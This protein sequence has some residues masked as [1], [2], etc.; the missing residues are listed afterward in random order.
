MAEPV[1]GFGDIGIAQL[2]GH[3]RPTIY[4][5]TGAGKRQSGSG[6]PLTAQSRDLRG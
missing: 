5:I 4:A 3:A 6:V 2:P 1:I